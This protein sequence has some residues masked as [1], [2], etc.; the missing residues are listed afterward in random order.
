MD[1]FPKRAFIKTEAVSR[2]EASGAGTAQGAAA[3][4]IERKSILERSFA[5]GAEVFGRKY[6]G[7]LQTRGANWNARITMQSGVTE[8]ALVGEEDRKKS[9]ESLS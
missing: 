8:A 2:I 3:F 6:A 7:S 1:Q 5:L 4:Q 9:V